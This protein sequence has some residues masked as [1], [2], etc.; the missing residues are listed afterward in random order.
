MSSWSGLLNRTALA[1][2]T[3]WLE[4]LNLDPQTLPPLADYDTTQIGLNAAY[5][6]RWP[7]LQRTPF[8]LAVGDGAAANV[9][10]GAV[11]EGKIALTVGTTAALRRITPSPQLPEGLWSYRVDGAHY[12]VGGAT[13]E[14]GNIFQWA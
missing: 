6:E 13:S 3:A 11:S 12:L 14:G 7:Q 1:W 5:R 4:R 9:G 8:Y 2:D 10:C